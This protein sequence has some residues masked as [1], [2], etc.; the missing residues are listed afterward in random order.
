M[1][2]D[3]GKN[4]L[5]GTHTAVAAALTT[6]C[7]WPFPEISRQRWQLNPCPLPSCAH[8]TGHPCCVAF[9]REL[10][11]NYVALPLKSPVQQ[12]P[13]AFFVSGNGFHDEGGRRSTSDSVEPLHAHRGFAA[14]ESITKSEEVIKNQS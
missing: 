1:R 9:V 4:T 11:M 6:S 3:C 14:M 2:L 5:T 7:V 8:G 12:L 10:A 13:G